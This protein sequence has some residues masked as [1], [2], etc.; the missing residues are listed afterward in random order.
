M[1]IRRYS[2]A[3]AYLKENE[4]LLI[5]E[6]AMNS[7]LLGLCLSN[8]KLESDNTFYFD[9]KDEVGIQ[10]T[11]IKT[12]DRNLII[13]GSQAKLFNTIPKLVDFLKTENITIPGVV[14][15]KD[16]VTETAEILESH[17]NWKSK[18]NFK[19]LVYTLET[20]KHTPQIDGHMHRAR[21]EELEKYTNWINLFS[22]EALNENN[23]DQAR[24]LTKSKINN[25]DLYVWKTDQAVSMSC[26]ARPTHNG[27][28]INYVFTPEDQ[29]RKGYGTKLVAEQSQRMLEQG[30][31][32]CTLFADIENPT[33]NNI[34]IKIGYEPIGEFRSIVFIN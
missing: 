25:G 18:V 30:Y 8:Q 33:S 34:Y 10:L 27:I 13:Y 26:S 32:F 24:A 12:E 15:P 29:R 22:Q 6:E 21:I 7:L 1:Y 31:K 16:L 17:Y 14:G 11:G 2:N 28:T 23:L 5:R 9:I 20:V 19:H 3:K 4:S